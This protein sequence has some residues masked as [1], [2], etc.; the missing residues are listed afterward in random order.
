M[1]SDL[2]VPAATKCA[3][4]SMASKR[5]EESLEL[6]ATSAPRL[7][8]AQLHSPG[9]PGVLLRKHI[10]S[11]LFPRSCCKQTRGKTQIKDVWEMSLSCTEDTPSSLEHFHLLPTD[12][13]APGSDGRA[14]SGTWPLTGRAKERAA[15]SGFK[16]RNEA[17]IHLILFFGLWLKFLQLLNISCILNSFFVA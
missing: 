9:S 2:D 12:P 16:E 8:R 6:G 15:P 10:S 13:V 5:E 7:W 17:Q 3:S 11:L 1:C 14:A 4:S